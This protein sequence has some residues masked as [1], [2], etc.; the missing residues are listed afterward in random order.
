MF[1]NEVHLIWLINLSGLLN[2]AIELIHQEPE[3]I[4]E[5]RAELHQ[6]IDT[7]PSK[8]IESGKLVVTDLA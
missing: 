6:H 3:R 1:F 4:A 7:R 8:T 5:N 2:Q